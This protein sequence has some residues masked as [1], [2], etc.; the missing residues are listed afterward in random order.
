MYMELP[1]GIRIKYVD[2]KTH[3]LHLFNNLYGQKQAGKVW[4]NHLVSGLQQIGF[5]ESKIDECLFYIGLVIFINYV[6][7]G[8]FASPIN[9]AIDLSIANLSADKY[10]IEDQGILADYLGVN[11]ETLA[12]GKSNCPN[13]CSSFSS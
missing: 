8:I 9:S 11:I 3:V 7:G 12:D 2:C 6:N 1:S 5:V 13:R 4:N 10:D